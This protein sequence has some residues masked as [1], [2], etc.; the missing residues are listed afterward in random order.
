MRLHHCDIFQ[1]TLK[2]Y[3]GRPP[4]KEIDEI[5]LHQCPG[6]DTV[7]CPD[8][9]KDILFSSRQDVLT[10][11]PI[12]ASIRNH[13]NINLINQ[14]GCGVGTKN[15]VVNG[16]DANI[17]EYP[18]AALLGY[19]SARQVDWKC[20]GTLISQRFVLTAFHCIKKELYLVRLGEHTISKQ[21][22]C[23]DLDQCADPVQDIMI[24]SNIKHPDFNRKTKQNDLAL[25]KLMKPADLTKN[26]VKTI[27]LPITPQNNVEEYYK[28]IMLLMLTG[29]GLTEHGKSSDIL[30]KASIP[31]IDSKTCNAIF[32]PLNIQIYTGQFCAGF[33]KDSLNKKTDSCKG[34]SGGGL[35]GYSKYDEKQKIMLY[36]VVS[37][38]IACEDPTV[39]Y[40][41]IYMDVKS[42]LNWI[43]DN[44]SE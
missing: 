17:K 41:G 12:L 33:S 28:P 25:L 23:I 11:N 3:G 13:R 30:Q 43:L 44:M 6:S 2:K 19:R 10:Q 34:D 21:K 31:Y 14:K 37:G 9:A 38:G 4:Q 39:I 32:N 1:N 26:N 42:Y 8:N 35:V 7:C 16:V 22:D 18:W 27:C 36:G 40:P 29:W 24:D 20:G 15:R 5:R